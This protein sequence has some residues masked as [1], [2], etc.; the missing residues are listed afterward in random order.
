MPVT[1]DP[2]LDSL[3]VPEQLYQ[4]HCDLQLFFLIDFGQVY[5]REMFESVLRVPYKAVFVIAGL[6]EF[7]VAI[8]AEA[9]L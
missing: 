6:E 8:H 5:K 9:S 4:E 2:T 1:T 7:M 3:L